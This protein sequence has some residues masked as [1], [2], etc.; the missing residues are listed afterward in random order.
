MRSLTRIHFFSIALILYSLT[1][2]SPAFAGTPGE[3]AAQASERAAKLRKAADRCTARLASGE[4][5]ECTVRVSFEGDRRISV[6]EAEALASQ[7]ESEAADLMKAGEMEQQTQRAQERIAELRL[8]ISK[9]QLSLKRL[10]KDLVNNSSEFET[11]GK[12]VD[13]AYKNTLKK[14]FEYGVGLFVDHILVGKLERN[15]YKNVLYPKLEQLINAQNPE[16]KIWLGRQYQERK[17]TAESLKQ[18]VAL[19]Q[20]SPDVASSVAGL[21][22]VITPESGK[23]LEALILAGDLLN[24]LN[25]TYKD[26]LGVLHR[27]ALPLQHA[28]MIGEAYTDLAAIGFSW[29]N[30]NKLEV[31]TEQFTNEVSLLSHRMEYSMKQMTCLEGCLKNTSENC[32]DQCQG[33]S[34]LSSPVPPLP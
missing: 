18:A 34:R 8:D 3:D 23:T 21:F 19:L 10:T 25:Q 33:K 2:V 12:T 24:S 4:L 20:S 14:T 15:H 6:S 30:I 11:W 5:N 26:E 13:D 29:F 28:R 27:I 7:L 31:Q 32:V 17:V 9:T 16:L 1:V 22:G